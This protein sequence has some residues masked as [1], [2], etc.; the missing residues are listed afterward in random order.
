MKSIYELSPSKVQ[1]TN[2]IL[3]SDK[4]IL[5][6]YQRYRTEQILQDYIYIYVHTRIYN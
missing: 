1:L 2:Q 4:Q 6:K 3:A 5:N